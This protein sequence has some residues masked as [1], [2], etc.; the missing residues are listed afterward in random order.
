M[1]LMYVHTDTNLLSHGKYTRKIYTQWHVDV[2]LPY[3]QHNALSS[4][5]EHGLL[6]FEDSFFFNPTVLK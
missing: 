6:I 5:G 1:A 3:T 4:R 2:L